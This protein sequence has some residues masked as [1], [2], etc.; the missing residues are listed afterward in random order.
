MQTFWSQGYEGTS[1]QD[2]EMATGLTRTSLYNA[3]GNKRELFETIVGY[4]DDYVLA[5]LMALLDSGDNLQDSI[6]KLL[7]GVLKLHFRDDS[8]G[9][10]LLLLSLFEREQHDEQTNAL[11]EDAVQQLHKA[12]QD[13]ILSAQKRGEISK[14]KD[15]RSLATS[16]A[17]T[18]AGLFTLGKAGFKKPTL[19]KS[20]DTTIGL[21]D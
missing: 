13:R 6:R 20:I 3:Y 17:T 7:N 21:F 12:L 1:I 5:D 2:L 18:M 16:V 9:G 4:Y 11:L 19:R 10:C 8:P 15:A 14:K